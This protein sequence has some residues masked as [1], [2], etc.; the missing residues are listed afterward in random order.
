MGEAREE[1]NNGSIAGLAVDL[2]LSVGVMPPGI[3]GPGI[4][5]AGRGTSSH[6]AGI[7]SIS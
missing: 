1:S 5:G 3:Q 6:R 4:S 7:M 2:Y